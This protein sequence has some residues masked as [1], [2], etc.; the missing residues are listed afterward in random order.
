MPH[1]TRRSQGDAMSEARTI[2]RQVARFGAA[3]LTDLA[4][5]GELFG[6]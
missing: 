6:A 3:R 5:L 4:A 1:P 2:R